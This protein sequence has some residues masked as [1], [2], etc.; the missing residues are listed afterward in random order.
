MPLLFEAVHLFEYARNDDQFDF[1]YMK[2]FF[3]NVYDHFKFL[4]YQYLL[5]IKSRN[6]RPR[7]HGLMRYLRSTEQ[8]LSYFVQRGLRYSVMGVGDLVKRDLR[9]WVR[10]FLLVYYEN[11]KVK[12]KIRKFRELFRCRVAIFMNRNNKF[13]MFKDIDFP[14]WEHLS[15][16]IKASDFYNRKWLLRYKR[17]RAVLK[18]ESERVQLN[19]KYKMLVKLD[20]GKY[21]QN[22]NAVETHDCLTD[23]YETETEYI[24]KFSKEYYA[25]E[26]EFLEVFQKNYKLDQEYNLTDLVD[27]EKLLNDREE[28]LGTIGYDYYDIPLNK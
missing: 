9:Q 7:T 1:L 11:L 26:D 16:Y 15:T 8:L 20:S 14:V 3:K 17:N 23:V 27:E 21:F 13:K 18:K 2:A 12:L 25:V 10:T 28:T 5:P 6:I 22:I 24:S 19:I 4:R